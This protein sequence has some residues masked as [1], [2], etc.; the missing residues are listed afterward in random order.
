MSVMLLLHTCICKI[1]FPRLL[2]ACFNYLE[3]RTIAAAQL[4]QLACAFCH[5]ILKRKKY[6]TW[7]NPFVTFTDRMRPVC[8]D[9]LLI[10]SKLLWYTYM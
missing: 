5:T 6:V 10:N 7:L 2:Y 8:D 3:A 4:F 9:F 1:Q